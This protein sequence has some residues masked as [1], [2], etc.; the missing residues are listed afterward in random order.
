M[1]IYCTKVCL[2]ASASTFD[3]ELRKHLLAHWLNPTIW[4]PDGQGA[5]GQGKQVYVSETHSCICS[6]V[7]AITEEVSIGAIVYCIYQFFL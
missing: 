7:F 4:L 3:S 1:A 2:F 5:K 6:S